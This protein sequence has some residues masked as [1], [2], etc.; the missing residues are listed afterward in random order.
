MTNFQPVLFGGPP[1]IQA[2]PISQGSLIIHH[3]YINYIIFIL[4]SP[5]HGLR[6]TNEISQGSLLIH[7]SSYIN[8][9]LFIRGTEKEIFF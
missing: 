4:I 2:L 6:Q 8:Y 9:I 7:S 1:V 5:T 3:S